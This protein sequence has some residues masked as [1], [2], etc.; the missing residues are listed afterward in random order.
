M[1][2]WYNL[3]PVLDVLPPGTKFSIKTTDVEAG[4]YYRLLAGT[5]GPRSLLDDQGRPRGYVAAQFL[6]SRNA[7]VSSV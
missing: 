5:P 1:H 2:S 3:S 7:M 6:T 4:N